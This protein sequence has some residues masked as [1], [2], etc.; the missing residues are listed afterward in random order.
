MSVVERA[1]Q[2][3]KKAAGA[4]PVADRRSIARV[5]DREPAQPAEARFSVGRQPGAGTQRVV[6]FDL[7]ALRDAGL[8]PMGNRR[9]ADEYR[10]IKR[11]I[12]KAIGRSREEGIRRPNLV[13]ISSALPGEGKTFTSVNLSMS[14]AN[15]KDWNVLLV[16]ADCRRPELSRLLGVADQRGLLDLLRDPG[17]SLDSLVLATNIERLF[18]LP[19]GTPA[20]DAAELIASARMSEICDL[21]AH[22]DHQIAI[23]DSSPL[24]MTTG[25]V[26][27]S[28]QCG[29][30][31]V[32]VNADRT[33]QQAVIEAVEKLDPAAAVGLIMNRAA[34]GMDSLRYGGYRSDDYAH[35][36]D[37]PPAPADEA[38]IRGSA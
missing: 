12:L 37:G 7:V 17:L 31:L 15:E 30:V 36:D 35:R 28:G 21:L 25:P 22:G 11:P 27:L 19:L 34:S 6:E 26:A 32:V 8:F 18:V 13:M 20:D 9:L 2:N 14:L 16:D 1:L 5:A 10:I 23:W 24:L 33:P 29:Q 4:T 3:L 38:A